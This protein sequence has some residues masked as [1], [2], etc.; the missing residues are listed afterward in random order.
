MISKLH[1]KWLIKNQRI[2]ARKS[3]A[4][5]EIKLR[6]C[7]L[8]ERYRLIKLIANEKRFLSLS[9][10]GAK[11]IDDLLQIIHAS[12]HFDLSNKSSHTDCMRC[13]K[14]IADMAIEMPGAPAEQEYKPDKEDEDT[15]KLRFGNLIAI[16]KQEVSD[17]ESRIESMRFPSQNDITRWALK[18]VV[19]N[20]Y[21]GLNL[22]EN[23]VVVDTLYD[24]RLRTELAPDF[25]VIYI[26]WM[27]ELD[28]LQRRNDEWA[29]QSEEYDKAEADLEMGM[30]GSAFEKQLDRYREEFMQK[31]KR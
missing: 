12:R 21:Q 27:K 8:G 3:V 29:L 22:P 26:A 6:D 18:K 11:K 2:V 17:E 23:V 15:Y 10:G 7:D 5:Y 28:A 19:L 30:R 20:F 1:A 25:D 9:F 13:R 24:D 14:V 4:A 31:F 16:L